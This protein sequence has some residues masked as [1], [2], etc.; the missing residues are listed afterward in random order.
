MSARRF[1]RSAALPFLAIAGA[2]LCAATIRAT[3]APVGTAFLP[4]VYE[5][6]TT[7]ADGTKDISRH[8]ATSK[9]VQNDTLEKRLAAMSQD[10]SCKFTQRSVGGGKFAIAASCENEG[11]KSSYQQTGTY[12]PTSMTM[13]MGMTMQVARGQK[14]VSMKFTAL[15]KRVAATCPAGMTQE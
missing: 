3:A 6:T 11:V 1:L 4:G 9:G 2:S 10:P 8:C 14:P 12:T 13:T 15:S 5:T 7:H